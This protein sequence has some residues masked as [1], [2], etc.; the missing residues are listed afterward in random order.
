ML[1]ILLFTTIFFIPVADWHASKLNKLFSKQIIRCKATLIASRNWQVK[2]YQGKD[3][4]QLGHLEPGKKGRF[5]YSDN[6]TEIYSYGTHT[7]FSQYV[8]FNS[9]GILMENHEFDNL[10]M[11]C[12]ALKYVC[13]RL[14]P[15]ITNNG[16]LIMT[17]SLKQVNDFD[18]LLSL[19][20]TLPAAHFSTPYFSWLLINW[21]KKLGLDVSIR[22]KLHVKFYGKIIHGLTTRWNVEPKVDVDMLNVVKNVLHTYSFFL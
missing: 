22:F 13:L 20:R 17:N 16:K 21:K 6:Q 8:T 11:N 5:I 12:L 3:C 7:Y 4:H 1:V 2:P 14:Y 9:E 10:L 18:K 19:N 15:A